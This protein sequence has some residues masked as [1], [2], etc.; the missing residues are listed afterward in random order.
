MPIV[1][2]EDQPDLDM[3]FL[4]WDMR[5]IYTVLVEDVGHEKAMKI[6]SDKDKVEAI[7]RNFENLMMSNW[8]EIMGTAIDQA[9]NC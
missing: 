2:S 3:E 7:M 9:L 1:R 4:V 8:K 5:D 6:M